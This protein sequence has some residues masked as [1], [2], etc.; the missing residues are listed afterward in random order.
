M[1]YNK[2]DIFPR[3]QRQER[4]VEM[5]EQ[6]PNTP[7]NRDDQLFETLKRNKIRRKR[8]LWLTVIGIVLLVLLALGVT[9][10][11]LRGRVDSK[12]NANNSKVLTF[13]AAP[14]SIST[15]VSGSGVLEDM[16]L[17]DLTVP[18]GVQVDEVLVSA[19]DSV[20]K[21]DII[22]KIDMPSVLSAMSQAQADL[23]AFDQQLSD[24]E[25][26]A[27]ESSVR[28]GVSGRVK[29]IYCEQDE[30]V[31]DCMYENGALMV[32]S[33]DGYMSAV[34]PAGGLSRGDPVTAVRTGG[35]EVSGFVDSIDSGSALLLIDD[36]EVASGESLTIL[37]REGK[38][39]AKATAQIHNPLRVTG[40]AGKVQSISVSVGSRVS[41]STEVLRLSETEYSA[42]YESILR[43]R[44]DK[45]EELMSLLKLHRDGALLAPFDGSVSSVPEEGEE[46]NP[47]FPK[48][49]PAEQIVAVL[50]PDR[51]MQVIINVDES[52]ILSLEVGQEVE[53]TVRSIGEDPFTGVVSEIDQAAVSAMGVTKY[54]AKIELDKQPKMLSG[55]TAKAVV[56]IQ[57]VDDAIIIPVDALHQTSASSYVYTGYDEQAGEYV[58]KV[59]VT[60]G[61]S[62]ANYVE[63]TSGLKEGDTVCYTERRRSRFWGFGSFGGGNTGGWEMPSDYGNYSYGGGDMPSGGWNA[64]DYGASGQ[65]WSGP[66]RG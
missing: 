1:L 43:Q 36:A 13:T 7:H 32:I 30:A 3:G 19:N 8:R 4:K 44:A 31:E 60:T 53:L 14:G 17:E 2:K 63:I 23:D 40:F 39:L 34:I 35:T 21:G 56:R 45:E 46:V 33:T 20:K 28:A 66:S 16:D 6:I 41:A 10:R 11:Y 42:N 54:S 24:A 47:Y 26:D 29:E 57:G 22:A 49:T 9:V 52:D 18:N 48:E 5:S 25:D 55:M 64:G 37:D 38:Q 58:G 15:T 27:V 62:N 65:N 61:L 51:R 59:E 50:S 12:F